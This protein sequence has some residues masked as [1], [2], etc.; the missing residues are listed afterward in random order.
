MSSPTPTTAD[1]N[2]NR[3]EKPIVKDS[4]NAKVRHKE[5]INSVIYRTVVENGVK[6]NKRI[7]V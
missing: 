1:N 4:T 5:K 2:N 7:E 6:V 3:E